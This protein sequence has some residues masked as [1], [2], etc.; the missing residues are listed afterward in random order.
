MKPAGEPVV[1]AAVLTVLALDGA[2]CALAA[3]LLLPL[4]LGAV[5]LPLSALVAGVVNAALVG[6]AGRW[7]DSRGLAALPLWA[8]LA[9][10]AALS[11]GGPGGDIVFGGYWIFALLILGVLPPVWVLRRMP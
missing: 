6:A 7:T 2:L 8:W 1:A 3:A 5:P 9:V 4:Y 10:V 11:L